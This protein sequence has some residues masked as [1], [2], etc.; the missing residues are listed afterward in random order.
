MEDKNNYKLDPTLETVLEEQMIEGGVPES[1][2]DPS[3]EDIEES[4]DNKLKKKKNLQVNS[5]DYNSKGKCECWDGYKR[6]PGTKPCAPGSCEKC[7]AHSKNSSYDH[8]FEDYKEELR[9]KGKKKHHGEKES[10][11]EISRS[12]VLDDHIIAA[13]T[14][15]E[16]DAH[17]ARSSFDDG[18]CNDCEAPGLRIDRST[19]N[20]H[21]ESCGGMFNR[22][23][24][25]IGGEHIPEVTAEDL[26]P[27]IRPVESKIGADLANEAVPTQGF[28]E[29]VAGNPDEA[30]YSPEELNAIDN[31]PVPT[32]IETVLEYFEY[33][34]DRPD[35][36]FRRHVDGVVSNLNEGDA[37]GAL[38]HMSLMVDIINSLKEEITGPTSGMTAVEAKVAAD[39]ENTAMPTQGFPDQVAETDAAET[40]ESSNLESG[41]NLSDDERSILSSIIPMLLEGRPVRNLEEVGPILKSIEGKLSV[42]GNP[43]HGSTED[44][45][46]Q[47]NLYKAAA[48]DMP[49]EGTQ[50][51]EFVPQPG[52]QPVPEQKDELEVS[53]N[54]APGFGVV[55]SVSGSLANGSYIEADGVR[56]DVQEEAD[57]GHVR[58]T[59]IKALDLIRD[60]FVTVNGETLT[61]IPE[62]LQAVIAK[63]IESSPDFDEAYS[64]YAEE[65]EDYGIWPAR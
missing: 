28:P 38:A 26:I 39:L 9:E 57:Q 47:Y 54:E 29:Q 58:P 63:A 33:E 52:E 51:P 37:D 60:G 41:I 13:M 64:Y 31:P 34:V 53:F 2:V 61:E 17:L 21:C 25:S 22:H 32:P 23:G 8:K 3:I 42:G 43:H 6:V 18:I 62:D 46:A 5:M 44:T 11:V 14:P 48:D 59:G 12:S 7:D 16:L 1:E 55:W 27:S 50:E 35:G 15:D 30:G 49:F 10:S 24:I 56:A 45:Y 65:N 19:G 20:R 4:M 36:E 40:V